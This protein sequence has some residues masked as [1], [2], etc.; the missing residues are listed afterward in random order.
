MER[1]AC[2]SFPQCP[3]GDNCVFSH[4]IKEKN[5]EIKSRKT[6]AKLFTCDKYLYGNCKNGDNC[7]NN[8]PKLCCEIEKHK[9]WLAD[10]SKEE[11]EE[12]AW[13]HVRKIS[14]LLLHYVDDILGS[15]IKQTWKVITD[16]NWTKV[17]DQSICLNIWTNYKGNLNLETFEKKNFLEGFKY[18][19]LSLKIKVLLYSTLGNFLRSDTKEHEEKYNLALNEL[20]KCRRLFDGHKN[21]GNIVTKLNTRE[22]YTEMKK[23]IKNNTDIIL[24]SPSQEKYEKWE[25]RYEILEHT[26]SDYNCI[27]D[28]NVLDHYYLITISAIDQLRKTDHY[29]NIKE[30]M[31]LE[32][33]FKK[34]LH[35][36]MQNDIIHY[37]HFGGKLDNLKMRYEN[38][39]EQGINIFYASL[40]SYLRYQ[41]IMYWNGYEISK[42][43]L[44]KLG[45]NTNHDLSPEAMVNMGIWLPVSPDRRNIGRYN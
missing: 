20:L 44:D 27:L 7:I 35:S 17:E 29:K 23:E 25:L 45:R 31:I 43:V 24:N 34:K 26:F 4:D 18:W 14:S 15:I 22:K 30:K 6:L 16:M 36:T 11:S 37:F 33:L 40:S 2:R 1:R 28:E 3:Y 19:D 5:R 42:I 39:Y 12:L 9:K 38:I 32:S 8:H 13:Y 41:V 10:Q 21:E